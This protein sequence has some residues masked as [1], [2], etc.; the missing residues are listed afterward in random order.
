MLTTKPTWLEIG[1]QDSGG[2][3][4]RVS[5][6]LSLSSMA[7]SFEADSASDP[8]V[9]QWLNGGRIAWISGKGQIIRKGSNQSIR[10]PIQ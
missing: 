8:L 6:S 2:D 10:V 5:G 7:Y 3:I 4:F 1:K 9:L